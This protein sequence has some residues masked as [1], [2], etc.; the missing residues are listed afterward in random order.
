MIRYRFFVIALFGISLFLAPLAA[1]N[2]STEDV[3][4]LKLGNTVP[5]QTKEGVQIK[6]WLEY[7]A[8]RLNKSGGLVVKGQKYNVE[9]IS[10]DDEYSAE[11]GK[12]CAEKLIYQD[13]VKHI[14]CQWGSPPILA[15]VGVA[16]ANKVLM[17]CDGATEKTM[18]PKYHYL[19]RCPSLFWTNGYQQ[20][21]IDIMKKKGI[22]MTAVIISPDSASGHGAAKRRAKHYKNIGIKILDT[23]FY[24]Q[25]TTDYT[26]Y[27]TKIKSIN[28]GFVESGTT[29]AGMP[30][31][32]LAKALYQVGYK[33]GMIFNSLGS[34]YQEVVE[35]LG[36]EAIEGAFCDIR[37]PRLY[38]NDEWV[39]ELCNGYEAK[40]GAWETDA[41]AWISGWF[42]FME[43]VKRAD[44]L[45]VDD[46]CKVLDGME[47]DT[48]V[49]KNRFVA[50]PDKNNPRTC[51]S[52][53]QQTPG[54]IENGKLKLIRLMSIDENYDKTIR[55]YG[56]EKEYGL[57]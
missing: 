40:Y 8:E 26:P 11:K 22:P 23:L 51:D 47:V 37:D 53:P 48:L 32:L 25:G 39:A 4:I 34:C 2:A 24:K 31:L 42:V 18:Q 35:K 36:P 17:I 19:Y 54:V 46:L 12:A 44:S 56:L 45:D 29:T 14:I 15:T 21:Y 52:V 57:K 28:P 50:R 20:E 55:A 43:A 9:I 5:M 41:V 38:R 49:A 33:G 30:T 10:Y 6:R 27:A 7:L 13:G 1:G 3:K 16:E